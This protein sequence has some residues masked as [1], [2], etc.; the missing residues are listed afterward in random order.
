[1]YHFEIIQLVIGPKPLWVSVLQFET[2][3]EAVARL[4]DLRDEYPGTQF[5]L[6]ELSA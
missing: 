2:R 3:A 6:E 4:L 1:M 5:A